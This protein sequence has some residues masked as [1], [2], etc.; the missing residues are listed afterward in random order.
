VCIAF[1]GW[2]QLQA[3]SS[4]AQ[5]SGVVTDP[6]GSAVPGAEVTAVNG[7]TG[8]PYAT[9]T[10]GAG[11]YVLSMRGRNSAAPLDA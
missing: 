7:A 10:N 1:S 8:V 2:G 4:N 6:S 11:V 9:Q 3:Q 5:I